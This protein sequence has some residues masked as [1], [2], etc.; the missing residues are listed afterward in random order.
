MSRRDGS[1]IW[2]S[3]ET[4]GG[5]PLSR[6]K[7]AVGPGAGMYDEAWL[8]RFL[9]EHPE[10]FPIRQ[11]EPGFDE[12]LPA[13]RE[14]SVSLGAGKSGALDN[15]FITRSGNL[16]LIETKLWRNPEARR[17]VV[18]QALDYASAV[19]RMSYSELNAA[20][21]RA[22]GGSPGRSLV[23]IASDGPNPVDEAEFVDA[24]TSNL[25]RGKAI[26]AV[27]GDGIRE[28]LTSIA[29]LLQGHAGQRFTFAL[30]ELAIYETNEHT[31][32]LVIPS[33]LAQTVL[34][35]RGVIR[36]SSD[37]PKGQQI[38]VDPPQ[39]IGSKQFGT[40]GM[41]F[42]ED[43]FYEILERNAPGLPDLL[44]AFV[45]KSASLGIYAE[46]LGGLNL[47]HASPS[48]NPLNLA[49]VAKAG[50]VDFGPATWWGSRDAARTYL[51]TVANLAGASV[52]ER[53]DGQD[54]VVRVAGNKMPKL[55]V[56][57]P[58]HEQAWLDAMDRYIRQCLSD[59]AASAAAG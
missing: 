50:F 32:R 13:C 43:E 25:E 15:L 35:E 10:V 7:F 38:V 36:I 47:K 8:Q 22:R 57:L 5:T 49:A 9:H 58:Q 41:S 37:G 3:K 30:V 44:K 46:V 34:L 33:V 14:L 20:V 1:P 59:A 21:S 45:D 24:V 4:G 6:I 2:L 16:V 23:E 31:E 28:D 29:H 52:V 51:A 53:R 48:G 11:I 39:E 18:A 42:G 56:L 12:L 27:V 19:F 17:A 26:V 55:S 54:W 40:R